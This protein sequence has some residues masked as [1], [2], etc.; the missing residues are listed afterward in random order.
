MNKLHSKYI[1]LFAFSI[2][3][4]CTLN[5]TELQSNQAD[6][7]LRREM[8]LEAEYNPIIRDA[9]KVNTLPK[10]KEPTPVKANAT[11]SNQAITINPQPEVLLLEAEHFGTEDMLY[12]KKGYLTLGGGNFLNLRGAAGYEILNTQNDY[13]RL[14]FSHYSTNGNVNYLENDEKVK[15]KLNDNLFNA[16]Y[17]HRFENFNLNTGANYKY[18]GFNYY[19]YM[20]FQPDNV[21][22]MQVHQKINPH[23][24]IQSTHDGSVHYQ[25]FIGYKYFMKKW[26]DDMD[27]NGI[28]ENDVSASL[29]VSKLWNNARIGLAADAH[30]FIYQKGRNDIELGNYSTF[31]FI[32]YYQLKSEANDWLLKIGAR[33]DLATKG[34]NKFNISPDVLAE[35]DVYNGTWL[36]LSATG[37][38]NI[39]SFAASSE[40]NRYVSPNNRI[41][42]S[43]TLIDSK[44]GIRSS[45]L[46]NW[47]FNAFFGYK[48]TN[49]EHFYSRNHSLMMDFP[50][51]FGVGYYDKF[52]QMQAGG[53]IAFNYR[54]KVN[55]S[56]KLVKNFFNTE[57]SDGFGYSVSNPINLP[58][59]ELNTN[60]EVGI[61][62]Q[63]KANVGFEWQHNR[64][65][66]DSYF[67]T[68][69]MKDVQNLMLGANYAFNKSFSLY[70][71]LNNLLNRK[72]EY[73]Y[74]YPEQ[75]LNAI[76]GFSFMF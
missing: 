11:Y 26:G 21:E 4:F 31:G 20:P 73:W 23:L 36:Y 71:Q 41:A 65:G 29:N 38:R 40:V 55:L 50:N 33:A 61:L 53:Q 25:V 6:S 63:L 46:S 30:N 43:H 56:V 8:L 39:N 69:K 60:I 70:L 37:G 16:D 72:Y 10:V 57:L 68:Y 18:T 17:K 28:K 13:L 45:A 15:A 62:P 42:D 2:L 58:D 19:G 22:K 34:K 5:A 67:D 64:Y 54:E 35:L 1:S 7:V 32:P 14:S 74:S 52:N 66:I 59:L 48:K 3:S 27:N 51:A 44:L 49:D 12:D 24:S 9:N 75:G 47:F 76:A